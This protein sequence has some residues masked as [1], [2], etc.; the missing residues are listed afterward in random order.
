M[1]QSYYHCLLCYQEPVKLIWGLGV[2]G[3]TPTTTFIDQ[4]DSI[5]AASKLRS[6]SDSGN[7][8]IQLAWPAN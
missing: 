3:L 4:E 8:L 6:V 1:K 7:Q 5:S 2:G